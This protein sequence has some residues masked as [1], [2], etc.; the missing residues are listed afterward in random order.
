MSA[1]CYKSRVVFN[2]P[3]FCVLQVQIALRFFHY[4][5]SKNKLE[6]LPGNG[7]IVLELIA[8]IH[9]ALKKSYALDEQR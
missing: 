5:I 2:E 1:K 6:M 9:S 7:T 4:V 3:T 8:N